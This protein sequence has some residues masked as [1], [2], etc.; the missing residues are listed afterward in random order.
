MI[1]R[2]P[3]RPPPS[4]SAQNLKSTVKSQRII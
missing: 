1:T 3:G 2:K 4:I